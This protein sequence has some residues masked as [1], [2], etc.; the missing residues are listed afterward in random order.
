MTRASWSTPQLVVLGSGS[1]AQANK[2]QWFLESPGSACTDGV[3]C[4]GSEN[5]II[6]PS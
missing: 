6:G 2:T 3:G 5:I 1:E 4:P